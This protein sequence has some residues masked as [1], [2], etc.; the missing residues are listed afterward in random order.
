MRNK[1]E[2]HTMKIGLRKLVADGNI[3]SDAHVARGFGRHDGL[4]RRQSRDDAVGVA[5]K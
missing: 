2:V 3:T 5:G 4:T 1:N